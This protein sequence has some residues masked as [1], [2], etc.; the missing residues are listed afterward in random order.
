MPPN[1]DVMARDKQAELHEILKIRFPTIGLGDIGTFRVVKHDVEGV[2]FEDDNNELR[3]SIQTPKAGRWGGLVHVWRG[4]ADRTCIGHILC[5]VPFNW[6]V[7]D[8]HAAIPR[9][10]TN[11]LFNQSDETSAELRAVDDASTPTTIR[12]MRPMAEDSFCVVSREGERDKMITARKKVDSLKTRMNETIASKLNVFFVNNGTININLNNG[13]PARRPDD[14]LI[15]LVLNANV[16]FRSRVRFSP[17]SATGGWS[18]LYFCDPV[19]NTWK[20]RH[21]GYMA[22]ELLKLF[23]RLPGLAPAELRHTQSRRGMED[24]VHLLANKTIAEGF[25]DELDTNLDLFALDNGVL[26]SSGDVVRFR[27]TRPEDMISTTAGWSY[28]AEEAGA[29]RC[30]VEAFFAQ[31]L[32]IAEERE[33][34]LTFFASL[35]SGRRRAKKFLVLTD[36]SNG[37][38]GKSTITTLMTMFFGKFSNLSG[39]KF[40]CRPTFDKDRDAHDAGTEKMRTTRLLIAEEMKSAMKLDEAMMKKVAGGDKVGMEGRSFGSS[41]TFSYIWQAGIVLVFNE[42]D[43]P[44]FDAGDGPFMSRMMIAPMRSKF[45]GKS[46]STD[47]NDYEFLVSDTVKDRFAEMRSALADLMMD[48]FKANRASVFDCL[49]PAMAEWHQGITTDANPL[50]EWLQ[51]VTEVTKDISDYVL[52]SELK[53]AFKAR[54]ASAS[55][56]RLFKP[57]L[58]TSYFR[59]MPG[60]VVRAE[61]KCRPRD[62][63]KK[64]RVSKK[65]V[66]RGVKF[67]S[68]DEHVHDTSS[69]LENRFREAL[70]SL[71]GTSW[72]KAR[73]SWLLNPQTGAAMELDMYCEPMGV[74]VEYNGSQHYEYPNAF[75][76]SRDAFDAQ[77]ARD[78]AKRALCVSKGVRLIEIVSRSDLKIETDSLRVQFD[79]FGIPIGSV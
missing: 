29:H 34:V 67:A 74:A 23:K 72:V 16:E 56:A 6:P 33:V 26:D 68:Q 60:V 21:N 78:G 10:V 15:E 19:S 77:V 46:P 17:T 45:V 31:V 28:D 20:Q 27:P 24:M 41:N 12:M 30:D 47:P 79:A 59:N 22:E 54:S 63:P 73:P 43:C 35:L 52:A 71:T 5:D 53:A 49:P 11:F 14:T 76:A 32:P 48:H 55:E 25:R 37:N 3:G 50:A 42:G 65:C 66:I 64:P 7:N 39:T 58:V 4:D 1:A 69:P 51:S 36:R 38:N 40:V 62:D 75:H 2:A 8:L 9:R 13:E 44:Q 70:E 61:D 57:M 18:G